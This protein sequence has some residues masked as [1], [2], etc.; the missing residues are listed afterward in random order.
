MKRTTLFGLA[1]FGVLAMLAA[2][3]ATPQAQEPIVMKIGTSTINDSQHEW[4][5]L[6]KA[7]IE[8]RSGGRISVEL[9]PAN[10]LGM[11][12]RVIEQTQ[13]NTVQG[14]V[15]PPEFLS[16]VDS[17]Y[18]LLSAPGL[19]DDLGHT[20][21]TLQDPEFNEA[22]L[23]LGAD[24]G[25]KGVG[26]FISGP[27]V[28]V[29]RTAIH[30]LA[31]FSGLKTR[32]LA[33]E[34][35]ME[36]IRELGAAPIPMPLGEVLPALQQGALDSVMSC[37]PV[38]VAL[39]YQDAAKYLVETNHGVIASLAVVSLEWLEQLPEDLQEIIVDA[40]RQVSNEVY[41]F[42]VKDVET[43]REEWIAG[44]GEVITLAP[45]EQERMMEMLLP[46][47]ERVT[48]D[49]PAERE[50]FDLLRAAAERTR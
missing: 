16:G 1:A 19:F 27:T 15:G 4:M 48:A 3:P 20:N 30:D 36:Q 6:Y 23:G 22:F 46:V 24:R 32:V 29:S 40:G 45:E 39:G 18:Q 21:R 43:G 47:G 34:L 11:A 38:F 35:Q 12:P 25:L 33:A 50:M 28:F 41:E 49:D 13:M 26:L 14:F 10:Q 5:K 7:A 42:S 31:G 2:A 17:R 44:G 37:I 9:Y 8:E